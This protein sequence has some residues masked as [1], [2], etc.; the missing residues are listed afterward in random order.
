[1]KLLGLF[2]IARLVSVRATKDVQQIPI[3]GEAPNSVVIAGIG[4]DDAHGIG[5]HFTT[6]YAVAVARYLNGTT[7]DVATI[8]ADSDYIKVMSRWMDSYF[9]FQHADKR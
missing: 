7:R 2:L 9:H 8:E 5:I 3:I 4:K 1:M 6:S